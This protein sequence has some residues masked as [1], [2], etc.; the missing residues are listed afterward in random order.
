MDV[1]N[2]L[3]R[4]VTLAPLTSLGVGGPAQ[5]FARVG[6]AE[7]LPEWID[8]AARQGLPLTLLGG[9]TN[10][11]IAD[12]G[13]KDVLGR[14]FAG[15]DEGTV[16][17]FRN[18]VKHTT[19]LDIYLG[20]HARKA[21]LEE[22]QWLVFDSRA[23]DCFGKLATYFPMISPSDFR[24]ALELMGTERTLL[25]RI[26][27]GLRFQRALAKYRRYGRA[28]QMIGTASSA[29]GMVVAKLCRSRKA[30]TLRSGGAIIVV[31]GPQAPTRAAFVEKIRRWLGGQLAVGVIHP[32][33]PPATWLSCLP[34][35]CIAVAR[36]LV[37]G[38]FTRHVDNNA[39]PP[40]EDRVTYLELVRQLLL[41]HE[42][43]ALL[44]RAY[45][46]S[47]NGEIIICDD[48]PSEPPES[49]DASAARTETVPA[50]KSP[51]K[52]FILRW[53]AKCDR[54]VCP[55]DLV[56]QLDAAGGTAV[57]QKPV[58]DGCPRIPISM[59]RE[60]QEAVLEARHVIWEHL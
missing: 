1:P 37:P 40:S 5:F 20:Q 17:V 39:T 2:G 41:A 14:I 51:L 6:R 11:V 48:Y 31:V 13:K 8:W 35:A 44:R 7:A 21:V 29:C 57:K 23:E 34:R 55:P 16:F 32:G 15:D 58:F 26:R 27:M 10:V 50:S 18:M 45:R 54:S 36:R 52:R 42:R 12:A 60:F 9:G 30:M 59:D 56:L 53:K 25:S 49:P 22:Y 47:R 33:E 24:S 3:L 38:H 4:G 19:L 46:D 28:R 43:A